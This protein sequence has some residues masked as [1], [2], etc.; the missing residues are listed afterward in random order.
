MSPL[1]KLFNLSLKTKVFPAKWKE[2]DVTPVFNT[3][4][5]Q[6]KRNY[7]PI[8]LLSNIGKIL[9]RIF[10]MKLYE[11]CHANGLLT[12]RNSGY[13]RLDSTVN[14]MIYTSHKIYE[15]LANGEDVCFVSLDAYWMQQRHFWKP[16]SLVNQ[17]PHG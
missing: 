14:Q 5:R 3:G 4:D 7:R 8:S 11:Y 16:P 13:K 1:Q 10:F 9:E 17:L 15:A 2:A 6:D 12:W